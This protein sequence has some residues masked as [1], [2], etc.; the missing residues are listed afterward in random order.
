LFAP[1]C[2]ARDDIPDAW[3]Q[4][5]AAEQIGFESFMAIDVA[6]QRRTAKKILCFTRR[7]R[8]P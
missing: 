1:S 8:S 2:R 6:V 5:L 3:L 4:R 7:G